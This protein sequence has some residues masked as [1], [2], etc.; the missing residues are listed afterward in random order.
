M[1]SFDV[2]FDVSPNK[3]LN[4]NSSCWWF[5]WPEYSCDFTVMNFKDLKKKK[6]KKK[7]NDLP[8]SRHWKN[9]VLCN[10]E[11]SL[12]IFGLGKHQNHYQI[13]M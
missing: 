5:E 2:F 11:F 1:Q 13:S 3:L 8:P 7:L 12:L 6:K 10:T 4:K 9:E